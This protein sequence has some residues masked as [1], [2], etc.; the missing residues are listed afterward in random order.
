MGG[1][2]GGTRAAGQLL[3]ISSNV[4]EKLTRDAPHEA[5]KLPSRSSPSPSVGPHETITRRRKDAGELSPHQQC[6]GVSALRFEQEKKKRFASYGE[7]DAVAPSGERPNSSTSMS[8]QQQFSVRLQRR[9]PSPI[10]S[11]D[12]LSLS[13]SPHHSVSKL[14]SAL[15]S[16][17]DHNRI[18]NFVHAPLSHLGCHNHL[19][20]P[21]RFFSSLLQS[22]FYSMPII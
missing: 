22:C 19:G 14:T 3:W 7:G 16:R 20:F 17:Y 12:V 2:R 15:N 6:R 4:S 10:H 8:D 1:V 13:L 18:P 9:N 5:P 21:L 11:L